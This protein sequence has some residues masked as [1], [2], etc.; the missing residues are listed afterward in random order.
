MISS[1]AHRISAQIA[2]SHLVTNEQFAAGGLTSVRG[3]LQ[4]EGV[5]DDGV[6]GSFEL[7]LPSIAPHLPGFVDELRMFG[8]VDAARVHVLRTLPEQTSDFKLLSIGGWRAHPLVQRRHRGTF[9]RH[10]AHGWPNVEE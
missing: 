4:S 1:R 3:Y 2:D 7:R 8:F 6:S 10:A 9:G 5:G